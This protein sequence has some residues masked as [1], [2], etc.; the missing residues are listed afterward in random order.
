MFYYRPTLEYAY[1][2][3]IGLREHVPL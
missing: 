1:S 2:D 3:I